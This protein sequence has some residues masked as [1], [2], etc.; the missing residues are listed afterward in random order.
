MGEP[1]PASK[2]TKVA[3]TLK[4]EVVTANCRNYRGCTRETEQNIFCSK[5]KKKKIQASRT[6]RS[7]TNSFFFF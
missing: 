6:Q 3:K 4:K 7:R 5:K 2:D 1:T